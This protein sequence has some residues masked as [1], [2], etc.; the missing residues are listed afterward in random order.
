MSEKEEI[1]RALQIEQRI[2]QRQELLKSLWRLNRPQNLGQ[3]L[4]D[5]IGQKNGPASEETAKSRDASK[6]EF[7]H[8]SVVA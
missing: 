4:T 1:E 7:P 3:S 5:L 8:M 2:G 6:W